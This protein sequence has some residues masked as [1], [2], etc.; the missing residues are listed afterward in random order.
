MPDFDLLQIDAFS[1]RPLGGNPC[2]VVLGADGLDADTMLA[3]AREMNLSETAFVVPSQRADFGARYFTPL[4]EVPMAGHP[5]VA[6]VFA[7]AETGALALA[8]ELTHATLELPA[9]VLPI[10]I[11]A[12]EGRVTRIT[13]SQPRPRFGPVLEADEVEDLLCKPRYLSR[14]F[15]ATRRVAVFARRA[16][17]VGAGK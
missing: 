13:M 10:E 6:T 1:D 8:G 14:R 16:L 12:R 15:R 4:G 3:V 9:G 5:T 11:E 17:E 2:A 7:L